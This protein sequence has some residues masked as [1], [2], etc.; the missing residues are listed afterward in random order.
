MSRAIT[1]GRSR[2][3]LAVALAAAAASA[4]SDGSLT[5]NTPAPPPPAGV[6]LVVFTD[7]QTGF[8]T[9]DVRD[10]D[11]EVVRFDRNEDT[12]LWSPTNLVFD[13]WVVDGAFLDAG[14][15]YRVAFGTVNG[16]RRAYFTES[17]GGT[18]CDLSVDGNNFLRIAPT[19]LLP[20]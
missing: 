14:R 9:T 10:A 11:N 16:Q 3:A 20:P 12:L 6:S 1:H 2:R 8:Q 17:A 13:G 7:P 15:L 18:I 4:C 5:S 19:S